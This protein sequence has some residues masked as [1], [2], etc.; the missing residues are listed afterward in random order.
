MRRRS[1][2]PVPPPHQQVKEWSDQH[3]TTPPHRHHA[4]TMKQCRITAL[5]SP[6]PKPST[7][8]AN[9]SPVQTRTPPPSTIVKPLRCFPVCQVSGRGSR[10]ACGRRRCA[11][12]RWGWQRRSKEIGR[13]RRKLLKRPL[14]YLGLSARRAVRCS[15]PHVFFSFSLFSP[16]LRDR[17]YLLFVAEEAM[18][19]YQLALVTDALLSGAEHLKNVRPSSPF[20]P[21]L[22][23]LTL[24]LTATGRLPFRRPL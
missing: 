2:F 21:F 1:R 13:R 14:R 17:T 12:E 18:A 5:P 9:P 3:R 22:T 23:I 7:S 19:L 10:N 6:K 8:P 16:F 20:P 11:L 4:S 24:I 15:A